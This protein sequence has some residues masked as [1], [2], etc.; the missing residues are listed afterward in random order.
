MILAAI[1]V[2]IWLVLVQG[3][4]QVSDTQIDQNAALYI[5][6]RVEQD[7][8]EQGFD[9][10]LKRFRV[11]KDPWPLG[12]SFL[13]ISQQRLSKFS[14]YAYS[15]KWLRRDRAIHF[16]TP[17]TLE[18]YMVGWSSGVCTYKSGRTFLFQ[19]ANGR[20]QRRGGAVSYSTAQF[21]NISGQP[22]LEHSIEGVRHEIGHDI[23]AGHISSQTVMNPDPLG[24]R[25]KFQSDLRW[26]EQ[27]IEQINKCLAD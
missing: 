6:S 27:S 16:I 25:E 24:L 1:K 20:F 26:D 23:G 17:R 12:W 18:G 15:K 7:L 21:A 5:W 3:H 4:P 11:I 14:E 2:S 10:K 19:L 13:W 8:R 9:P 22:R